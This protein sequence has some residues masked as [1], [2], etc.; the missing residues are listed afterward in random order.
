MGMLRW[1]TFK[2]ER[3][4]INRLIQSIKRSLDIYKNRRL[5]VGL[6]YL[7]PCTDT[8]DI[9]LQS[10]LLRMPLKGAMKRRGQDIKKRR[11]ILAS[12]NTTPADVSATSETRLIRAGMESLLRYTIVS[13][14]IGCII[15]LIPKV[16]G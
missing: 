1:P 4:T 13:I 11:K 5:Q 14:F 2:Q 3:A 12:Y 7:T 15:V 16:G 6:F 10:Q 8:C 9:E